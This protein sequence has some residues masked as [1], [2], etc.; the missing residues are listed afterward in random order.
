MFQVCSSALQGIKTAADLPVEA[1]RWGVQGQ[2][3]LPVEAMGTVAA[4][5]HSQVSSPAPAIIENEPALPA[6]VDDHS[7]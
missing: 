1:G 6:E 5:M 7:E 2:G 3:P 4:V